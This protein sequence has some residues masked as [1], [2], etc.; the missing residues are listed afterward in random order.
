MNQ[1]NG[2]THSGFPLAGLQNLEQVM[3]TPTSPI[4]SKPRGYDTTCSHSIAS[5]LGLPVMQEINVVHQ[6]DRKFLRSESG[7]PIRMQINEAKRNGVPFPKPVTDGLTTWLCD[8]AMNP[9][10]TNV[11]KSEIAEKYDLTMTQVNNWFTNAR[12][13]NKTYLKHKEDMQKRLNSVRL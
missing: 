11:K 6:V 1:S 2:S 4:S 7:E 5:I 10:P 8:N 12:R 9:Y 13:R 3:A